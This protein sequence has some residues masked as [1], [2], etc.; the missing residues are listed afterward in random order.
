MF[1]S[2]FHLVKSLHLECIKHLLMLVHL[3]QFGLLSMLL[4]QLESL[5]LLDGL[6]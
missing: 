3:P 1:D 4:S 6:L 5:R 2:R